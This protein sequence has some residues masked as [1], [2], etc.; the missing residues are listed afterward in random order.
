MCIHIE[1]FSDTDST[2]VRNR[3]V[4]S[5]YMLTFKPYKKSFFGS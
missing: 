5:W 3:I 2:Y 4:M 1:L